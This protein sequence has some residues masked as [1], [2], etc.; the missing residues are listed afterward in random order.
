MVPVHITYL[1]TDCTSLGG[2]AQYAYSMYACTMQQYYSILL[3]TNEASCFPCVMPLKIEH[4]FGSRDMMDVKSAIACNM[5]CEIHVS[6]LL[7]WIRFL[8]ALQNR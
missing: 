8:L 6:S 3:K 1:Y 7:T 4:P 2:T 5:S